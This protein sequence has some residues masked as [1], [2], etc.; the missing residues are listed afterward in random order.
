MTKR[1]NRKKKNLSG[2]GLPIPFLRQTYTLEWVYQT[3]LTKAMP[4]SH[5]QKAP[6]G[7]IP[8]GNFQLLKT[9]LPPI[10]SFPVLGHYTVGRSRSLPVDPSPSSPG[11]RA[12]HVPG[13]VAINGVGLLAV[14]PNQAPFEDFCECPCQRDTRHPS[15]GL[16]AQGSFYE[17]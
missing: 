2:G 10:T 9:P 12:Y 8:N 1:Q 11:R 16:V 4:V 17:Q 15:R 3:G 7:K 14:P 5:K 6:P 13:N